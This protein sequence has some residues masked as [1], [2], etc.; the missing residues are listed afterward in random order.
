[1]ER[2]M[3]SAIRASVY[4]LAALSFIQPLHAQGWI[5]PRPCGAIIRP[6]DERVP[7]P[8]VDCRPDIA[9]TRSDVRVELSDRVLKYE[10]EERFINR[11]ATIGEADYLF[12]LPANAA[13]QD[14]KLSI[15]GELV[16]GETMNAGEA[17]GIYEQ[18][19]RSQR[20]PALVEWMGH[21]LLRARIFPLNPGEEKRV[22]VRFQSVAP[23]EGDALRVDYF[24]G[25]PQ[26]TPSVRDGGTSSFTLSFRPTPELGTPF[27]PTHSL[28]L[29]TRDGR[30]EATVRGDARDVTL[31]VPLR[32][33]AAASISMLPFAPG[34][35]DGFALV[36]VTPP[37]ASRN[38]T[39]PRD[40]TLV[41]DVSGS[42][43]GRK[44][45]QARAAGRQLL[46]TL[47]PDDRFRLIDFS[48]DV[49]TFKDDFVAATNANVRDANRYLD[50]LEAVGGTNIE[51]ALREAMRPAPSDGRLPLVL[52]IT[53]GEPTVGER[54]AGQL[55]SL[56]N[57]RSARG[58]VH[59]RIF[60]FGLGSDVNVSLLE[61]LALEGRGTAQFVRP[62]ESVERMVGIVANRLV[63]PVMTDVRV[64]V[65]GNVK[66]A[67]VLPAQ[68]TDIFADRDLVLLARYSGS[69]RA[70][71]VVEGTR[72]GAPVQFA[73]NVEFPDRDR[74]N[75][76]VARLWAAQR[77]GFLSAEKRQNGGSEVDEEIRMLG[78][79]YGI[80]T[81]FTSYLVVEP[82][83]ALTRA[84]AGGGMVPP[85]APTPATAMDAQRSLR[86]ES[87]KV[88][89][90]QRSA[91]TVAA[92]DSMSA[93]A[94]RR[95]AAAEGSGASTRVV[96]GH[97]FLLRDGVWTDA[98]YTTTMPTTKIKTFS[99]AYFDI[100]AQ[101]PELRS[102]LALGG[103]VIV[104]GRD[105]AIASGDDGVSELSPAV[106][107]ALVKAW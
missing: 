6:M 49:R 50:G 103:R 71:I 37:L 52:F 28:D 16:S 25:A 45:E 34:N 67:K 15:N 63:D 102:A 92:L 105:R 90:A 57:D 54:N 5:I 36:T 80:P 98:R 81:E 38:E 13:F 29:N 27:S 84:Q 17:R 47:R 44:M 31:L 3:N 87:A 4:A 74:Q 19:V 40:I 96:N 58:S 61:Q 39:T 78:E 77:V 101:L 46:G 2:H 59:R 20:D 97:T 60:T 66:L 65:D 76:F 8:I 89:S 10:V 14:L 70:R 30:R 93:A 23:R 18:I 88:A 64:R 95:D 68:P 41:L 79:R 91:N 100:V 32:R 48:S 7:R 73:S 51:G 35:E 42:M 69:G 94:P 99:K 107:A 21:G 12:P 62:E 9:R 56:G 11:G 104:V 72:H 24:R 55:A 82:R 43:Q 75:T 83:M 33:D 53:D 22:V 86:F 85:N 1:M 106:L 26:G